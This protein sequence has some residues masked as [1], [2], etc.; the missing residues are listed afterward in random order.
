MSH[1]GCVGSEIPEEEPSED[2]SHPSFSQELIKPDPL[3]TKAATHRQT[4]TEYQ[5]H[6]KGDQK[7]LPVT[8]GKPVR[9]PHALLPSKRQEIAGFYF[10]FFIT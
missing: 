3:D 2:A 6:R 1:T 8:G 4:D 5:E 7:S 9:R 10:S